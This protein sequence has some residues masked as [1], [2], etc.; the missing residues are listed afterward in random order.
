MKSCPRSS[1]STSCFTLI[2]LLV[3]IAII[4][5]LAAMLLPA[6]QKA[7]E[8]SQ[9]VSCANQ[10]KQH[11]LGIA[12]YVND[13]EEWFPIAAN[14]GGYPVQWRYDIR[15]YLGYGGSGTFI[16]T[17]VFKCPTAKAETGSVVYDAGYGWNYTYMGHFK[18]GGRTDGASDRQRES[19]VRLPSE[20]ICCGDTS[21][22]WTSNYYPAYLASSRPAF[23][24]SNGGNY[25]WA[26][27][28]VSWMNR[29]QVTTA[30]NGTSVYY[31]RVNK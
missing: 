3:V 9:T 20:T 28:H 22:L 27:G 11:S 30:V 23:H 31:Y 7:K 26:D 15:D 19:T 29:N 5:I 16:Y 4:A 2:E 13:S 24:H 1:C 17:G 21:E 12:M 10:C 6:L 14:G 8:K 25:T 18:E